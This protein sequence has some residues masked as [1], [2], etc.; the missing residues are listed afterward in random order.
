MA[1]LSLVG[2]QVQKDTLNVAD[3]VYMTLG[4]RPSNLNPVSAVDFDTSADE[5]ALQIAAAGPSGKGRQ[6]PRKPPP[7]GNG[8]LAQGQGKPPPK[9]NPH[10]DGPP[11]GACNTHYKYGRSAFKCRKPDSCPWASLATQK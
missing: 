8:G 9:G 11:P 1:S 3:S 6:Q 5:P 10:P 2:A 7:R 4:A